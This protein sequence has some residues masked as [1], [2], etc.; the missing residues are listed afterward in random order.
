ME[1]LLIFFCFFVCRI[2]NRLHLEQRQGQAFQ[3]LKNESSESFLVSR[4]SKLFR[5]LVNK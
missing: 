3:A 4:L 2:D 5:R 1:D